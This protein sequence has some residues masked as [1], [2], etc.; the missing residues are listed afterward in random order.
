[1]AHTVVDAPQELPNSIPAVWDITTTRLALVRLHGRN[2]TTWNIKDA[3]SA[4]DRFN[5]DYTEAELKGLVPRLQTLAERVDLLQVVFNNNY[6]D[7]G[8]RNGRMLV[9]LLGG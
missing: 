2:R 5:Y 1:V 3:K 9:S 7:Q 6:E 8:Q 4:S